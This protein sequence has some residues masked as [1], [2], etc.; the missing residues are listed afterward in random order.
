MCKNCRDTGYDK[1]IP[2]ICRE[3]GGSNPTV[4]D[5]KDELAVYEWPDGTWCWKDE[6]HEYG[7]K[8]DDYTLVWYNPEVHC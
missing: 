3:H 8:S 7:W 6:L 2:C 5:A 4:Q 1:G